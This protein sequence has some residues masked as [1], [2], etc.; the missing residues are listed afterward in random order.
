MDWVLGWAVLLRDACLRVGERR[1]VA[2][3]QFSHRVLTRQQGSEGGSLMEASSVPVPLELLGRAGTWNMTKTRLEAGRWLAS[4]FGGPLR[5]SAQRWLRFSGLPV[6]RNRGHH[7]HA[8]VRR[9][10]AICNARGLPLAC[11]LCPYCLCAV[12]VMFAVGAGSSLEAQG[13]LRLR[14]NPMRYTRTGIG[15]SSARNCRGAP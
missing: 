4:L 9:S 11:M 7:E 2:G 6:S 1:K 12:L 8:L 15:P 5:P 14:Y 13:A 10:E 3:D